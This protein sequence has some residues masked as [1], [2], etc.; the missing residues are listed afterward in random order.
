M[1]KRKNKVI[2]QIFIKKEDMIFE[3]PKTFHIK[4][5]MSIVG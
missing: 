5:H 1:C 3:I 4:N 2:E